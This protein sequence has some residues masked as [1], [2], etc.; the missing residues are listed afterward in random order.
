[1]CQTVVSRYEPA[2]RMATEQNACRDQG[3]W[4]SRGR[5]VQ[6]HL[7]ATS[8]IR[9]HEPSSK[10]AGAYRFGIVVQICLCRPLLETPCFGSRLRVG[11]T[12]GAGPF[13]SWSAANN[14]MMDSEQNDSVFGRGIPNILSQRAQGCAHGV[15]R[16]LPSQSVVNIK[17][18]RVWTPTL[19]TRMVRTSLATF[20]HVARR[21]K[22]RRDQCQFN[23]RR[24]QATRL[25]A[26]AGRGR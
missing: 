9:C 20:F 23:D 14:V 3:V 12:R 4:G 19:Q 15:W 26:R 24:V 2:G 13:G 21:R 16:T 1:M 10:L 11:P 18:D 22:H 7:F 6:R 17:F 5:A 25:F 8:P